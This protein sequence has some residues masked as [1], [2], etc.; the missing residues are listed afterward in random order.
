M[1]KTIFA[2]LMLA[3]AILSGCKEQTPTAKHVIFLG[4]DGQGS[5]GI[6]RAHTPNFNYMIEN[7]AI[8]LDTRSVRSTSSS[9]NWMS[10]VTGAP[11]EVHG[12][13]DNAW[14][15]DDQLFEAGSARNA[16]NL[17]PTMF[18]DIRAGR[19]DAKMYSYIEWSGEV[20]MYD[21]NVFDKAVYNGDGTGN[22]YNADQL[23]E[24]AFSDYLADEP[25][26]MFVSI[27]IP[28]H[29]GHVDGH[30][31]KGYFEC[32][33]HMDELVG[34]F[35]K[36]L[37][38]RD[39]LKDAVII[40]AADHGGIKHGHGG[41]TLQ[42]MLVPVIMYGKGV[43]KGKVMEHTNMIYDEAATVCGL[44]GVD[45]PREC[46]GKF[47]YEAFEP[48][49][50]VCYVPVPLVTPFQG[51]VKPGEKVTITCDVDGAE[52]YYTLD[53]TKPTRESIRYEGP[54]EIEE[55]CVIQAVGYKNG[56]YGMVSTN[57]LQG[58]S[59]ESEPC[60]SYKLYRGWYQ[61]VLPDFTKFGRADAIGEIS[62]IGLDELPVDDS[63]DDF[64]VIFHTNLVIKDS[65]RYKFELSSDDG[66]K[67]YIDGKLLINNDGSHSLT[68]RFGTI[69]LE[70]GDHAICV[71]Y[72]EDCEGQG[73]ELLY[74]KAD[75]APRPILPSELKK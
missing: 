30:E 44:L 63:E 26:F 8:S 62:L 9:Q 70:A 52:I 1:K 12:V 15:P 22:E 19:P 17:F 55:T 61:E 65:A 3:T 31:S 25:E 21:M 73:L 18:D 67:L 5:Y 28:D 35:V 34:K 24:M 2:A 69:D 68:S 42:E 48:K 39:M 43:T 58:I 59:S 47:L 51:V 4:F 32:V 13:Y 20:R 49:T 23:L 46:R 14:E 75:K 36:D 11:I 38:A 7:G 57:F 16:R 37:E 56:N 33:T 10:M 71:E 41:D 27:D 50:D 74:N 53:G 45:M 72:F 40:I 66:S 6:Q 60:V 64:A 29:A 54:F